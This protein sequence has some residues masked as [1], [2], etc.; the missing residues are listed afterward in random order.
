MVCKLYST[1]IKLLSKQLSGN[2]FIYFFFLGEHKST[3]LNTAFP[4]SLAARCG[5]VT[6][7]LSIHYENLCEQFLIHLLKREFLALDFHA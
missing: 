2:F 3:L 4:S 5:H 7:L 1:S 6:H